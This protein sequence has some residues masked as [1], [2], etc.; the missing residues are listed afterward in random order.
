MGSGS[1][2]ILS[3]GV[4]IMRMDDMQEA[5]AEARQTRYA[6][7]R[8]SRDMAAILVGNLRNVTTRDLYQDHN[9]LVALKKELSQYNAS[10]R[11]WKS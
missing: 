11:K 10:T 3:W 9:Y 1:L 7:E 5:I 4:R 8:L 2:P 6:I